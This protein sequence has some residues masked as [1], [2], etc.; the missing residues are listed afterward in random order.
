MGVSRR[1]ALTG[2]AGGTLVGIGAVSG[3]APMRS[4]IFLSAASDRGGG[5]WV[6]AFD[7]GGELF[8]TPLPGRGH[9]IANG[10]S[11]S[12]AAARRPGDWAAVLDPRDGH[13]L[14]LC[15]AGPGRHFYGHAVFSGDG[16]HLLTPENDFRRGV[17]MIAL[18]CTK[19]LSVVAE[20]PSGG[21]GPHE[22]AW[23]DQRTVAVANGGIRTHPAQPRRKLNIVEMQPNLALIDVVSGKVVHRASPA[24]HQSSIR[25]M[26]VTPDGRILLAL[27][28]E[29]SPATDTP[30]VL[31]FDGG[32]DDLRAL[33]APVAVQRQMRQ[34]TASA[35][36]DPAAGRA[37]VTA[38]RGHLVTFWDLDQGLL[39]HARI[40]DAGGVALDAGAGQ[41]VVTNGTGRAFRF[42]TATGQALG[43]PQRS[44]DLR[45]DNHLTSGAW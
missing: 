7:A 1:R 33:P 37:L 27:Q 23:L 32:K 11:F 8:R 44:H 40:R 2:L 9:E 20:W 39:G 43:K 16:S 31:V 25:H 6:A 36:V 13:L 38:P 21:V 12:F 35:C 10:S 4:P 3:C 5:H 18:R 24:D 29:G 14:H 15:H 22:I 28:H 26:D 42:D 34:Y 41:F 19:S 45:W 17:G 30:L